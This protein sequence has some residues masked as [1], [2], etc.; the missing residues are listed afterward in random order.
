MTVNII[1]AKQTQQMLQ[2]GR[3]GLVVDLRDRDE[4]L[5]GHLR[6]AINIPVNQILDRIGEIKKYQMANVLLY[7]E[8]GM[9]SISAGKVLIL[10]G[11][12]RVYSLDKGIDF[13]DYTLYS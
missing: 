8:H 11:F 9:K 10:N 13:Y 7:C 2:N 3:F 12:T 5:Q 6:G 4:F 1:T